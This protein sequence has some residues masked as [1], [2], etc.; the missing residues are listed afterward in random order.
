M[1]KFCDKGHQ[2]EDSWEICPT[3]QTTGFQITNP[4]AGKTRMES[5]PAR[6]AA[7]GTGARRTVL[8]SEKHKPPVVGW[9]VALSGDQRGE[10][11][12]V[13]DGKNVIGSGPE[14]Q[15][16]LRDTTIS[17]QHASLRY[18]DSKFFLTDLDSSNGTYVNDKKIAREQLKDND[19]VRFG[20]VTM[21]FKC[22]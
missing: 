22:L 11:F 19:S 18:E 15:I 6:D 21:K 4:S 2:M 3:C 17:G 5:E 7:A 10:D 8:L 12:R 20:D 9:F 14:A 1:A 16:V 13:R